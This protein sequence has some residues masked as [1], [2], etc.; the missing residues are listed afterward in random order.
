VAGPAGYLRLLKS[1]KPEK[2]SSALSAGIGYTIGNILIKGINILTLP[3]FSRIMTTEEFGIFNV[4]LSY[5]AILFVIVG[6][7]L[8]SSVR[9]ANLEFR[10]QVDRYCSSVSLIYLLMA[11]LLT[12]AVL[13]F[14]ETISG[15]LGFDKAVLYLLILYSTGSAVLTL[16]NTRI[17]LDYA[18]KRYLAVAAVNSLGNIVLSLILILTAFR[19]QREMGRILGATAVTTAVGIWLL[20]GMYRR[21]KPR[22]NR[23]YWRFGLKY[24]LPIVPH[25]VS[26]VLLA[27]FDRIMIRSMV[28][29][30]AAGIY[31]LAANIKLILT[32]ITSSISASWST[33]FYT[34][35]DRGNKTTIQQRSA[36]LGALFTILTVGLMALSPELIWLLGGEDYELAKYVAIPMVVDAFVLFLYDVIVSGEY[37]TKKTGFIMMGT[38]VAAALNVVLNY[39]FIRKYGFIAAAYTTLASYVCYLMLHLL[40]SRKLTGFYILPLKWLLVYAAIVT[41]AAALNLLLIESLLLRWLLCAVIVLPMLGLLIRSVG[42][43]GAVLRR[44]S[45]P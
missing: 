14:G 9:S 41:A 12:L 44:K 1:M 11:L 19:S 10:G 35:M 33:W 3:I 4:F 40:I 42:G 29:D 18:Y 38:V 2:K 5:D 36:Q 17:S 31:A 24:S 25:G 32:V 21:E 27:Q 20:A 15:I 43:I 28:S 8:H 34:E 6:F 16:Y 39:I 26:Q 7:A 45:R 13:L 37:Y 23:E 30:A 22:Y